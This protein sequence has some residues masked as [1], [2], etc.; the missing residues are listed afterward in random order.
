MA[1]TLTT[2]KHPVLAANGGAGNTLVGPAPASVVGTFTGTTYIVTANQI[3]G[4]DT[5]DL[6][7]LL[8]AGWV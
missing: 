2:L 7:P 3:S 1:N 8:L 6:A 5:R 4:V